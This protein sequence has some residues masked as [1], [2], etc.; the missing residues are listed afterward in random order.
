[1]VGFYTGGALGFV[2]ARA[3]QGSEPALRS[4]FFFP[5]FFFLLDQTIFFF[6]NFKEKHLDMIIG[7]KH[8]ISSCT[9]S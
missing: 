6:R 8:K 1:M 4:R 5:N 2:D 9:Y 7:Q 3:D